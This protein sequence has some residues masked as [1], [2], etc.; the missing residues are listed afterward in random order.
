[1]SIIVDGEIV[2]FPNTG[3][4]YRLTIDDEN[5]TPVVIAPIYVD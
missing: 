4:S 1:V 5:P 2:G 3:P